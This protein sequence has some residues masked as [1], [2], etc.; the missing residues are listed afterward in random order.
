MKHRCGVILN[1]TK[2]I[3]DHS[4]HCLGKFHLFFLIWHSFLVVG[5]IFNNNATFGF[6]QVYYCPR[7]SIYFCLLLIRNQGAFYRFWCSMKVQVLYWDKNMKMNLKLG[8]GR[9]N[10]NSSTNISN[11][12]VFPHFGK[13]KWSIKESAISIIKVVYWLDIPLLLLGSTNFNH[14]H[15]GGKHV[16]G[17]C[18]HTHTQLC[19]CV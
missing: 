10:L 4:V 6:C 1:F 16:F 5:I 17:Q 19:M 9:S 8:W 11:Y 3:F 7:L 2:V 15:T 14:I 13:R 12:Y 18:Q